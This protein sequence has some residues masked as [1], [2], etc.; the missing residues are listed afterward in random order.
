MLP[1]WLSYDMKRK[2]ERLGEWWEEMAL[3]KWANDNPAIVGAVFAVCTVVFLAAVVWLVWPEPSVPVVTYKKEWYY[4]SN[5]GELFTA[6]K[7]L[8]PPI[9]APS[10]PLRADVASWPLEAGGP[11]G[12]RAYVLAYVE[13]PNES[14]R[15]VAFLET[16]DPNAAIE[17]PETK[18]PRLSPAIRWGRGRLLRRPDDKKWVKGDSLY[19]Q[20]IFEEAFAPDPNNNYPYYYYPE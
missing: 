8:T 9:E 3:R 6:K 5:T 19:G 13:D 20:A 11:A 4:D 15:F 12:L 10:G 14:D 18:G 2:A 7:G 16:A 17:Y 1:D